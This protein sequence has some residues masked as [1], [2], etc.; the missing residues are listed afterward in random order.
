MKKSRYHVT[1]HAVVRYLE[2]VIGLPV[3]ELR[4]EI[5]RRCEHG[6]EAGATGVVSE[7]FVYRIEEGRVVTVAP[8]NQPDRC[9][10]RKK[11]RRR[12]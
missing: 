5:G 11:T 3:D 10:G 1:D 9:K 4:R 8:H 2:R 7:G 12:E 6:I